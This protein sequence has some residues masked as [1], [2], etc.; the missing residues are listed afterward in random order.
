[1]V[2]T[3]IV[4][5]AVFRVMRNF[6]WDDRNVRQD[7]GLAQHNGFRF[8]FDGVGDQLGEVLEGVDLDRATVERLDQLGHDGFA[9]KQATMPGTQG[10]FGGGFGAGI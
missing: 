1:M 4:S 9:Q 2:R 7:F 3:D 10:G 6:R 5:I 8:L